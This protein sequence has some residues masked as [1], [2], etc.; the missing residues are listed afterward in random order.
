[1]ASAALAAGSLALAPAASGAGCAPKPESPVGYQVSA[2]GADRIEPPATTPPIAILDSGIGDVPE[3]AGRVRPGLNVVTGGQ[4]VN[5]LDGHGTAVAT[6]AAGQAGGVRGVSPSSPVI[7]IK[8]LD[9]RG[10][11]SAPDVIAGIDAAVSR[12]A[13]VNNISAA[14][15]AGKPTA[16]DRRV[17]TAVERAVSKGVVVVAPSGNEGKPGIDIPAI[18]PHVLAV[19]ATD[20]SGVAAP[21]SNTG[22]GLDLV[23]P[24]ANISTAA[25]SFICS[26]GYALMTGTSFAVPAVAGAA[27]LVQAARPELDATQ[28]ADVLRLARGTT[29]SRALGFGLLDVPAA[30]AA[31]AP[32][33]QPT[34]VD[35]DVYWV[36][37][38][39]VRLSAA[40]RRATI[41]SAVAI[42]TDPADVY[43]LKLRRGDRLSAAVRAQ[44]ASLRLGLWR[45]QTGSFDITDGKTEH[46]IAAGSRLRGVRIRRGG[47]YYVSVSA[48]KTLPQGARYSLTLSR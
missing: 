31:P 46:R 44:G 1:L 13:K 48:V 42:H 10:E 40:R 5:D 33:A 4:N 41:D 39:P 18:Y 14:A 22:S 47:V 30:I 32:P 8:I 19:G 27:A 6:I 9:A 38:A 2:V 7:P 28:T 12:G 15:P 43:R 25:P 29:W 21:F 26:T 11:T 24:G 16:D 17:L 35:D 20:E 45:A 37:R 3:L 23:A 36:K 34:E